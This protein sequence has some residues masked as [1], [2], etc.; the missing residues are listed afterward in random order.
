M[1]YTDLGEVGFAMSRKERFSEML[2]ILGKQ[3]YIYV[4][5][6]C[7][8]NTIGSVCYNIVLAVILQKILDGIAYEDTKL[9]SQAVCIALASFL[10]AF[11]FEPVFSRIRNQCIR[12]TIANL[13][14]SIFEAMMNLPVRHYEETSQGDMLTTATADVETVE[15]IYFYHFPN[16]CFALIHGGIAAVLMLCYNLELGLTSLALGILQ[17]V[18]NSKL[19]RRVEKAARERQHV[20]ADSIQKVVDTL[21]GRTDYRACRSQHFMLHRFLV[22]NHR[23]QMQEKQVMTGK[24]HM[25]LADYFFENINYILVL[26]LGLF[27]VL[28]GTVSVGTVVAVISLQGNATYL[29]QNFSAFMAGI[30]ES[31]PSAERILHLL[32]ACEDEISVSV[33]PATQDKTDASNQIISMRDLCFGYH[34][35]Q[36]V[37]KHMDCRIEKGKLTVLTGNSGEGKSTWMKILLGFYKNYTGE[38]YLQG[39][40]TRCMQ[41][42]DI[43]RQIAYVDQAC[44]VF[45]MSVLD[46]VRMG[47]P[48]ASASEVIEACKKADAHDFITK[49]P[50]GYETLLLNGEN[51]SGGQRQKLALARAFLSS[52]PILL[53]DEGTANLDAAS[54]E[55]ILASVNR[56]KG[57]KTI[58]VISHRESWKT[59]ADHV[60]TMKHGKCICE[61]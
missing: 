13:R 5:M 49:L 46:N 11:V 51:L 43:N 48:D 9:L 8:C 26:G 32:S 38:Y 19:S 58:I 36:A 22:T 40:N 34:E 54:E 12:E 42:S 35:Q 56:M 59:C 7:L 33:Q 45:C 30:A 6:T 47:R 60:L 20:R 2:Q 27:M 44:F 14:R 28:N 23:L 50:N 10:I 55:K 21:D 41:E 1:R 57:E 29:F 52:R 39:V 3:K 37:L 18:I 4:I 25:E 16:L 53:I 31:L 15:D 24:A 17:S 61:S